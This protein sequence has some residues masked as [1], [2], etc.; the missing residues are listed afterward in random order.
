MLFSSSQTCLQT[1][2]TGVT[3]TE[4]IWRRRWYTRPIITAR[5]LKGMGNSSTHEMLHSDWKTGNMRVLK[6]WLTIEE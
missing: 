1:W 6:G 2:G 5:K 4:W 3:V